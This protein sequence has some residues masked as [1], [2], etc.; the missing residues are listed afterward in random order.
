M[1]IKKSHKA[2]LEKKK[3]IFLQIGLVVVLAVIYMAFEW[4]TGENLENTLGELISD[5]ID[6]E[7]MV[8]TFQ[9]NQPPPP[10][11]PPAAPEVLEIVEDDVEIED[12][13]IIE[14][15]ESDENTVIEI[16]EIEEEEEE[17]EIFNFYV[18]EDKPEFPF[19]GESGLVKWIAQNTKYPEI[20][21][22]NGITGKVFVQ[23]VIEKD[24]RVSSVKVMRK[25]DPYLDKEA[26][27]VVK[28]MPKWKPGKQRGK[29]VKVSFQVPISFKLY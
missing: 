25:V 10:P 29:A 6:E 28:S 24:G 22:E 2:N 14:D 1:E 26:V 11:P 23:F 15:T 17:E 18:L 4:T 21:K 7:D 3:S 19:G 27:R 13:L 9:D 5:Q 20:A 16:T 8:N 12:D